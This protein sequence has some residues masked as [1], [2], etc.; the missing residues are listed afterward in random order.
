MSGNCPDIKDFENQKWVF[1]FLYDLTDI[2][3]KEHFSLL[4]FNIPKWVIVNEL[5]HIKDRS[6]YFKHL[7]KN[8]KLPENI[9]A[10]PPY[11]LSIKLYV[12]Y[13]KRNNYQNLNGIITCIHYFAK[14]IIYDSENNDK[15]IWECVKSNTSYFVIDKKGKVYFD[16]IFL[17][18]KKIY[19]VKIISEKNYL[20]YKSDWDTINSIDLI[21][22]IIKNY[23]Q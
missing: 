21:L 20:P 6:S 7:W 17:K 5:K 3:L 12:N 4:D 22:N 10:D 14:I 18:D 13:N 11:T 19:V 2:R 15:K 9:K 1:N 23:N 8:N 16:N